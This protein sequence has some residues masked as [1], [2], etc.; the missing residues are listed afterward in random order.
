MAALFS[1]RSL[2]IRAAVSVVAA[3]AVVIG[4]MAVATPAQA[5]VN[6]QLASEEYPHMAAFLHDGNQICGASLI[7]PSW[8]LSAAHCVDTEEP[9][10]AYSFTIG[11]VPDLAESGGETIVADQ[12]IVHP[13]YEETGVH[14]VSLFHL[15]RPSTFDPIS[16]ADPATDKPLWE[17]GDEARVI[18][19]GGQFFQTPSID[20]QLREVDI[21]VVSDEDCETGPYVFGGIDDATEVCAGNLHGTEDSCQ[22]DSGGPLMVRDG[23]EWIQ[24]G[25]VSWGLGCAF[26]TAYGV[27]SRVGDTTLYNWIND[28]IGSATPP[29]PPPPEPTEFQ[30]VDVGDGRIEASMPLG[31]LFGIT[32]NEFSITCT[33]PLTQGLDAHIF[34]LPAETQVNGAIAQA[35]GE[36]AGI[37]YDIDLA[38]FDS[39]CGF[40]DSAE[41]V[42]ENERAKMPAGTAFV[43]AHNFFGNDT[44]VNLSVDVP[45]TNTVTETSIEVAAPSEAR[46]NDEVDLSATLTEVGGAAV[47]GQPVRFAVLDAAGDTV[48][49]VPGTQTDA[50]GVSTAPLHV[51]L[52]AGD[53]SVEALFIGNDSFTAARDSSALDVLVDATLLTLSA[54]GAGAGASRTVS[55]VLTDD[56]GTAIAGRTIEFLANCNSIGV[57]ETAEDGSASFKVP[58]RYRAATTQFTAIFGGDTGAERFYDA[59]RAGAGC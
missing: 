7:A 4:S 15:S 6:G 16:L 9:A 1:A 8:I 38:F 25:V 26:P 44:T 11:G 46:F 2:R 35:T 50:T 32:T 31:P 47:E 52:P 33:E 28:Q 56:S 17:P 39:D 5:I 34:E 20:E 59:S 22:G 48:V 58:A 10:S 57:A 30:T 24:M 37:G 41:T 21:P 51:D 54:E 53:Y 55:S 45:V 43:S 12:V 29:P 49:V 42:E 18:G 23:T 36:T 27:Y 19:Y 14:D 13:L 3:L 40:L